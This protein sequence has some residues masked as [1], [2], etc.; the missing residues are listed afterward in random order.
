MGML[1]LQGLGLK[2]GRTWAFNTGLP[3][4]AGVYDETQFKGLDYVVAA[5]ARYNIRLV[6]AIGNLWSTYKG[7][8][9]QDTYWHAVV[10]ACDV[11]GK[12]TGHLVGTRYQLWT[13]MGAVTSLMKLVALLSGAAGTRTTEWL[14]GSWLMTTPLNVVVALSC[15][16]CAGSLAC[17]LDA[18]PEEFLAMAE[19][20][21][22]GKSIA[23]FYSC[24]IA[25]TFEAC[26]G[27]DT[28]DC[29]CML[30]MH[31]LASASLFQLQLQLQEWLHTH[32]VQAT[33]QHHRHSCKF[34]YRGRL[35]G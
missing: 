28:S 15:Q 20:S 14:Q 21:A 1:L 11:C 9:F 6:L 13:L 17:A 27:A 31:C 16:L 12:N 29:Q 25:A 5:A 3:K 8:A 10:R 33:H 30:H 34:H 32:P 26:K 19:G 7:M 4:A 22:A 2:V 24:V 35:Q 18:G 23:D